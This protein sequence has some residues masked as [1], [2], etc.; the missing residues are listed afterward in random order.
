VLIVDDEREVRELF[1]QVL[2]ADGIRS[3]QAPTAEQAWT[4]LER[5]LVPAAVLLD[6]QMPG[7]GGLGF[8][9]RIRAEPRFAK[10]PVTVVTADSYI[11]APTRTAVEALGAQV[12][13]K[14]L[15]FDDI[16]VLAH[17]MIV[18]PA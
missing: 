12:S 8:L 6:L 1:A 5:G 10:L 3:V 4:L 7:M 2:L 9:L 14:P 15:E 13:F 11:A 16:L 17:R 18:S